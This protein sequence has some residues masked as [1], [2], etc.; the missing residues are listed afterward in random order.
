MESSHPTKKR[1]AQVRFDDDDD[2][3]EDNLAFALLN[4]LLANQRVL[5]CDQG[6]V[7]GASLQLPEEKDHASDGSRRTAG[8]GQQKISRSGSE[9][10]K[11]D[12]D[13]GGG[14]KGPVGR[15]IGLGTFKESGRVV[16]A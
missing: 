6:C 13:S 11:D 7:I 10:L 16:E 14:D 15:C 2:A 9:D 12:G 5:P 4:A 1:K 3:K 8:Q